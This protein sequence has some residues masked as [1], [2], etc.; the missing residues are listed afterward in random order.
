MW[1]PKG[2]HYY[3]IYIVYKKEYIKNVVFFFCCRW[4]GVFYISILSVLINLGSLWRMKILRWQMDGNFQ[5]IFK[6]AQSNFLRVQL[7][8]WQTLFRGGNCGF[9]LQ[10]FWKWKRYKIKISHY[11][12]LL[13]LHMQYNFLKDCIATPSI[14]AKSLEQMDKKW[15]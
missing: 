7:C 6:L 3:I 5:C 2:F 12:E 1:Y 13:L 11:I 10:S 8:F 9:S 4:L 15:N 14:S